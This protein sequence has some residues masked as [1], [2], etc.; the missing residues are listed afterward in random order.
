MVSPDDVQLHDHDDIISNL[1][2]LERSDTIVLFCILPE[3]L[4]LETLLL[5]FHIQLPYNMQ[6]LRVYS[7]L[8]YV[9]DY[10]CDLET[11][12]VC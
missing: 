5:I 1:Y 3:Y 7:V 8:L 11:H 2:I 6:V 10:F 4:L 9:L 12:T